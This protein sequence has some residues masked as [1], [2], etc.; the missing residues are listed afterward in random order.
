MR[1]IVAIVLLA[2]STLSLAVGI[3]ERTVLSDPETIERTIVTD[4]QAPAT[5]ISGSS[6]VAYPGRQTITVTG[7]VEGFVPNPEGGGVVKAS[8]DRVFAAYGKT[9]DV[10]AWLAPGRHT[11]VSYDAL[12]DSLV[13]LPR[14]GETFLPDPEGSDLWFAEFSGEQEISF[15][16]AGTED[17]TVLLMSDGVLPAPH[18]ITVSWPGATEAP[19]ILAAL[20]IGVL[21]LIAGLGV[22][23]NAFVTWRK[24]RGP[25]RTRTRYV[26]PPRRPKA[27]PEK[28]PQPSAPKK[29]GRRAA[30]FIAVPFAGSLILGL[31]ACTPPMETVIEE[32]PQ[33]S[34]VAPNPAVTEIQFANIMARVATQIQAADGELSVNLLDPR[35]TEPTLSARRVS[36]TV[37]R[38]DSEAGRLMPIPSTPIRLVV[39]QQTAGWPRSVF[40]IIQDEQDLDSPSLG[41][42]LRQEDPR[43]QYKLTYAVVLNPQVELPALPAASIGA[44]RLG[45]DSKLIRVTPRDLLVHYAD[46]ANN[47]SASPHAGEFSLATDTLYSQMGPEALELRQESFGAT[48]EVSWTTEA[49]DTEI[50]AF[51]TADAGA[52]VLGTLRQV[53]RVEPIQSGAAVNSSIG[54]RALTSL[55]QSRRGFDVDSEAQILFYVP[56]VGSEDG[57]RVL[58]YTYNLVAAREVANE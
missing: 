31:G 58:G 18:T 5:I 34:V 36:Y 30:P 7:S 39:P 24:R 23:V 32:T 10:M 45:G 52:I 2:I 21:T 26:R 56:P 54:I 8:T 57:I 3:A 49:T 20:I 25:R 19:W 1:L 37:T 22:S 42:V 33:T 12:T 51:S 17:I 38:A 6:L 15:S 43:S 35:V 27:R 28:R 48:V 13:L 29:H 50:V 46:V 4:T 55:S 40:G 9:L 16:L 11:K 41:V 53:E 47:G 44:A 14:S